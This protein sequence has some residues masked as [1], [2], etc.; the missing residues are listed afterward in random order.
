[1]SPAFKIE[2]NAKFQFKFNGK[3]IRKDPPAF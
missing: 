2:G 3:E 1:L